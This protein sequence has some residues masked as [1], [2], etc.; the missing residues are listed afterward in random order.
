MVL[1]IEIHS[2]TPDLAVEFYQ[3]SN[4]VQLYIEFKFLGLSGPELETISAPIASGTLV[5][6]YKK[7]KNY[8]HYQHYALELIIIICLDD[9]QLCTF[10]LVILNNLPTTYPA[11]LIS[12]SNYC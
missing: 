6:N 8:Q 12:H 3:K 5:F 7:S 2:F 10:R 11:K 1:T 9:C 4:S